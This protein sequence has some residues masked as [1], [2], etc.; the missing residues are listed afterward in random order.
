MTNATISS[1]RP[2][3]LGQAP[4]FDD[5]LRLIR[6]PI[7]GAEALDPYLAEIR[8][9]GIVSNFGPLSRRFEEALA[10]RLEVD[11]CLALSNLS[12]GLMYMPVAAGLEGGEVIMPS[13]TFA[14]T[15]HSMLLGGL[16]PI[17]A[18]IDEVTLTLDPQSV[19][20]AIGPGT[21]AVCGVHTYGTPCDVVGLE[22]LCRGRGLKLFFDSA[23]GLGSKVK[24][25]PVGRFGRAEGFSTSATK[26]IT[27]LGEGGFITTNDAAF[28]ERIRLARNWGHG[29]D[30][31]PAFPS[32]VAK[33]PEIAAAAGLILLEDLDAWVA[34]R[35]AR[36][37]EAS[38]LLAAVPG[39]R[40]PQVRPGDAS[41][42]KDFT[43]I[44]E[45]DNFGLSRDQL[46]SC[47]AAENIETRT[48]YAP[49][50]HLMRPYR[51][52]ERRVSLQVTER[53]VDQVVTLPLH[54]DMEPA[55]MARICEVIGD[56]QAHASQIESK[57][58]QN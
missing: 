46:A 27:T 6:P 58:G 25:V 37:R 13:M 9:S 51:K 53:L 10:A 14:A 43:I 38:D 18:D 3:V 8:E 2:A 57:L 36:V 55:V 22:N 20:R 11:H 24:G 50:L 19:A 40:L 7:P 4:A 5:L 26:V 16:R 44:V 54:N 17:F 34:A 42:H 41:G 30:Y 32:I 23:H 47:L 31:N 35:Q 15:A 49:P 21:V 12:T 29:G 45:A 28:A 33:L 1:K 39:I 52:V 48:Y 56:I